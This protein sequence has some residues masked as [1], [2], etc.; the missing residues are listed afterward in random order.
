[1]TKLIFNDR[2][3]GHALGNWKEQRQSL[4]QKCQNYKNQNLTHS[5]KS[6]LPDVH[7]LL[8]EIKVF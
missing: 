3:A 7:S 6:S 5:N 2:M 4:K 1:M 8:S